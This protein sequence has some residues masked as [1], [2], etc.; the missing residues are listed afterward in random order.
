MHPVN[1]VLIISSPGIHKND[2]SVDVE[3]VND[4]DDLDFFEKS[5][6]LTIIV[7]WLS[8]KENLEVVVFDIFASNR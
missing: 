7:S 2:A 4:V 3:D 1:N 6:G 8:L 5:D